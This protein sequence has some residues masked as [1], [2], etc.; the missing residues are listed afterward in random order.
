[1]PAIRA[2]ISGPV[3]SAAAAEPKKQTDAKPV[4]VQCFRVWT[5]KMVGLSASL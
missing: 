2:L 5:H 1:L 3:I 4:T